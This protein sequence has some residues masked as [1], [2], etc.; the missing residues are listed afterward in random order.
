LAGL[1]HKAQMTMR[2]PKTW[3]LPGKSPE[4]NATGDEPFTVT[5]SLSA[6]Y[7][8]ILSEAG[9]TAGIMGNYV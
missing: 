4:A 6:F 5:P 8:L 3:P 2:D 7:L 1:Y 9:Q